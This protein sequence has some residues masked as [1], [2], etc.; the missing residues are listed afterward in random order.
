MGIS[1]AELT[2]IE[3]V[4][5]AHLAGNTLRM[6]GSGWRVWTRWILARASAALP[7][8]PDEIAAFLVARS[9]KVKVGTVLRDWASIRY[10][11]QQA[12]VDIV[13]PELRRTVN[14]LKRMNAGQTQRQAAP[15]TLDILD[16]MR[17]SLDVE[18]KHY[19]LCETL[20]G[21][22]LRISEA[23]KLVTGDVERLPH[24]GGRVLIRTSKSDQYGDGVWV[25]L[26]K[27]TMTALAG[28]LDFPPDTPI[29]QTR[30]KRHATADYTLVRWIRVA[31]ATVGEDASIYSGHS[32]RVGCAVFMSERGFNLDRIM[33][34]GRWKRPETVMRYLRNMSDDDEFFDAFE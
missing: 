8:N 34:H 11:H 22:A 24:G 3:D 29:F 10:Y 14:G 27:R 23:A 32:G 18:R 30:K 25:K 6:Y 28:L 19:A 16:R 2:R 31:V 7:A 13:T 9:D 20:F 12:G 1:T 4:Q 26:P 33:R 5:A 17:D 21:G 15:L